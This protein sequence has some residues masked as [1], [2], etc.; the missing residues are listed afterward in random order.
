[1]VWHNFLSNNLELKIVRYF[2]IKHPMRRT[3]CF[4]RHGTKIIM[5]IWLLGITI[6]LPQLFASKIVRFTYRGQEYYDCRDEW[7]NQNNEKVNLVQEFNNHEVPENKLLS[8][9]GL[10]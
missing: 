1:M 3:S 4:N 6:G 7:K 5:V 10:L 9:P 2:A 8:Y